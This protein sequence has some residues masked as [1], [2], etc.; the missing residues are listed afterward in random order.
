[1]FQKIGFSLLFI[2]LLSCSPNHISHEPHKTIEDKTDDLVD[3]GI[4]DPAEKEYE[5]LRWAAKASLLLRG[6]TELSP[7]VDD[8]E[9]L[10]KMSKEEITNMYLQGEPFYKTVADFS[11]YYIGFRQDNL[12]AEDMP[13][14]TLLEFPQAITSAQSLSQDRSFFELFNLRHGLYT[15]PFDDFSPEAF[16]E[17]QLPPPSATLPL[18]TQRDIFYDQTLLLF[19]KSIQLSDEELLIEY[20]RLCAIS[21]SFQGFFTS[22]PISLFR[23]L[24]IPYLNVYSPLKDQTLGFIYCDQS[25]TPQLADLPFYRDFFKSFVPFLQS[26]KSLSRDFSKEKYQIDSL[27]DLQRLPEEI[28]ESQLTYQKFLIATTLPN[29]STNRNR[30][31]SAY[32]LKHFFC[33]DLTPIN[34]EAPSGHTDVHGQNPS[35]YACHYKLDPMAGFFKDLGT[36]FNDFSESDT[37][38]FDDNKTVDR[39]DYQKYWLKPNSNDEWN[40]GYIQST[41]FNDLNLYG[42]NLEDLHQIL[43]TSPEVKK[44]FVKKALEYATDTS[45]VFDPGFIDD[46][47]KKFIEQEQTSPRE[48]FK[49]LFRQIALSKTFQKNNRDP[50]LCYDLKPGAVSKG[51]PPCEVASVLEVHCVKCHNNV[52]GV[53]GLDLSRWITLNNGTMGFPHKHN[54]KQL[55]HEESFRLIT[56]RLTTTDAKKRMPPADMNPVARQ[57]LYKWLQQN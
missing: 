56:E 3:E 34:V 37:I 31:R 50:D 42:E 5:H 39:K 16:T 11:L 35:C 25:T 22:G 1:M 44:C 36:F 40:I 41:Q 33:D 49:N 17:I 54:H 4:L 30:R 53:S 43:K 27:T 10:K 45:Q 7:D 8:F 19:E 24:G 57:N 12:F 15:L 2:S 47:T 28:F 29:S 38:T 14:E 32:I 52:A 48:A 18:S 21:M 9:Q 55:S 6:Q 23:L 20:P 46:L 26:L 51:R 13:T